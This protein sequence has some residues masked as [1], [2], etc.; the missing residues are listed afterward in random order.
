[1][2]IAWPDILIGGLLFIA[3]LKGY[4]RGFVME[5]SGAIA[6]AASLITPWFY[7][8]IFDKPLQRWLHLGPGST[9]VAGMFAVGIATYIAVMLVARALN[10]VAKLPVLGLGNALAGGAIGVAKAAV[11]LWLLLYVALF[12]PLSG[13]IRADLHRSMLVRVLTQP[14]QRVDDAIIATLPSFVRPFAQPVFARHRA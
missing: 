14:N 8:G 6:L 13:D 4:K 7:G 10:M 11:A 3:L 1:V 5:L 9:H 12:F 2:G